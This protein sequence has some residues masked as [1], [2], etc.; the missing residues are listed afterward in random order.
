MVKKK[1]KKKVKMAAEL[2]QPPHVMRGNHMSRMAKDRGRS[3]QGRGCPPDTN[4]ALP[5]VT[6][7]AVFLQPSPSSK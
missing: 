5:I 6:A 7:E 1:K 2:E 3:S 4:P